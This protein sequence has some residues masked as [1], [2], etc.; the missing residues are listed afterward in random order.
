VR[1]IAQIVVAAAGR[2]DTRI[3]FTGGDR[4]WPGD[5]RRFRYDTSRLEALG[6]HPQRHSTD[7]VRYAVE[8]I[9]A[10]GF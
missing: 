10:N 9:L 2:P 8:R 1:E 6:W 5:V 7:A 3:V 4:G